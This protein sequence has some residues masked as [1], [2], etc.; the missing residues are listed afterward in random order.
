LLAVN[1][2]QFTVVSG[3]VGFVLSHPSDNYKG[4]ARMGHPFS[5]WGCF[6][7]S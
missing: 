3:G 4:V 6:L 1:S 5:C 2:S 7:K